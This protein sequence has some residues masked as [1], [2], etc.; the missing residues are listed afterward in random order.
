MELAIYKNKNELSTADSSNQ[1]EVIKG[2]VPMNVEKKRVDSKRTLIVFWFTFL[3]SAV[4]LAVLLL[5]AFYHY[6]S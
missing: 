1:V 2:C 5:P 4:M 6:N 3:C